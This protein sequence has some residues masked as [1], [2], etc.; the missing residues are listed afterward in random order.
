MKKKKQERL[1]RERKMG[2]W[3]GK[4]GDEREV[5]MVKKEKTVERREK[6]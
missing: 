1:N 5:W 2:F 3:K 6:L 4:S